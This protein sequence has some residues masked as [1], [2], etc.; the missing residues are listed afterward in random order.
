MPCRDLGYDQPLSKKIRRIEGAFRQ[1]HRAGMRC[2][3][4]AVLITIWAGRRTQS[5]RRSRLPTIRIRKRFWMRAV[6]VLWFGSPA[7]GGV[8]MVR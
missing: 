1:G 8:R 2:G 5:S 7:L 4:S 3:N 6:C